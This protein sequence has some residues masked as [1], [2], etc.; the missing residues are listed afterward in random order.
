MEVEHD[1]GDAQHDSPMAEPDAP[2]PKQMSEGIVFRNDSQCLVMDFLTEHM[3][4][5]FGNL[6]ST[7]KTTDD[8]SAKPAI[9]GRRIAVP[10]GPRRTSS[11]GNFPA[12]S[13]A[14]INLG[15]REF[16]QLLQQTTPHP[17]SLGQRDTY[18]PVK[19][20][21]KAMADFE[22]RR[23]GDRRPYNGG[24]RKRGRG[25]KATPRRDELAGIVC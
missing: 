21:D 20:I 15:R 11:R 17:H 7:V 25:T 18:K 12:S 6:S 16:N 24:G 23:G 22:H 3:Q 5:S 1:T 13:H 2:L 14:N 4:S 8:H 19:S 9:A 10:R